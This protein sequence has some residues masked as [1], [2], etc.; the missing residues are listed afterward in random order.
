MTKKQEQV[1]SSDQDLSITSLKPPHS[2]GAKIMT[3]WKIKK[4]QKHKD[5]WKSKKVKKKKQVKSQ[6]MKVDKK[7]SRTYL[8]EQ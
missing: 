5:N 6:E 2:S 4:D 7:E 8:E 3:S 1:G